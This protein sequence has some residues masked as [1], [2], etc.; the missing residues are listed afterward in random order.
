MS[1]SGNNLSNVRS[2]IILHSGEG[3]TSFNKN[4]R[5]NLSGGKVTTKLPVVSIFLRI[6]ENTFRQISCPKLSSPS[7]QRSL[8]TDI[9]TTVH[10]APDL[11]VPVLPPRGSSPSFFGE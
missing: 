10:L 7:N 5:V 8:L 6:H 3:L 1:Y 4:E 9:I 11:N 2:F